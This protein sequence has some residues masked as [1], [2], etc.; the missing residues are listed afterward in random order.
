LARNAVLAAVI[1]LIRVFSSW[2]QDRCLISHQGYD[3]S[4]VRMMARALQ[5]GKML[6]SAAVLHVAP[7]GLQRHRGQT[8]L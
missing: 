5:R 2:D 4:D 8:K 1:A 6:T 7:T 3:L